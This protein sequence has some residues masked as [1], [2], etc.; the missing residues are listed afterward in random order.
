MTQGAVL[1]PTVFMGNIEEIETSVRY[2]N[3]YAQPVT[4]IEN[5]SLNRVSSVFCSCSC[6]MNDTVEKTKY[7]LHQFSVS[8]SIWFSTCP[9]SHKKSIYF[10][11][12]ISVKFHYHSQGYND[13]CLV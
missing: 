11:I 10:P 5:I 12:D 9:P 4:E 13:L 3:K 2:G 1:G 6:T 8:G 7:S